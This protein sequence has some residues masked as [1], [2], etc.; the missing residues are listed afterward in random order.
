MSDETTAPNEL[1]AW[2]RIGIALIQS[3][4]LCLLFEA[5]MAET[6]PFT[7][8]P[9]S[10]LVPVFLFA[11]VVAV[12][13]LSHLSPR[14]LIGW[15]LTVAVIGG[16][17]GWYSFTRDPSWEYGHSGQFFLCLVAFGLGAFIAHCLVVAGSVDR[18]FVASYST[19]FETSWKYAVQFALAAAFTGALWLLLLLGAGLF[20]LIKIDL[21]KLLS[22]SWFWIPVTT[23]TATCALHVTDARAGIVH[24]LR[25]L[26][27]NLFSWL[28]P[29][30]TAI[31][32]AFL[33]SLAFTGLEPLWNT[34]KASNILLAAAASLILL[35]NAAY[36]DGTRVDQGG[37]RER[38]IALP[39]RLAI[40]VAS[41]CL[42]PLAG[43]AAYGI[44]LRVNQYGWSPDRVIAAACTLI[45][46]SYALGYALAVTRWKAQFR[47]I[48]ATNVTTAL[49]VV[50]VLI[51]LLTPIADPARISVAS[52]IAR[53]KTGRILPEAFDYAFLR[54]GAGRFG[55]EALQK[56]AE[57]DPTSVVATRARNTLTANSRIEVRDEPREQQT[58][59]S[60]PAPITATDRKE[61]IKV[62]Y[63]SGASL[64]QT[65]LDEDW[66]EYNRSVA[67]SMP[68]CLLS[69][70]SRCEAVIVD[71]NNDAVPEIMLLWPHTSNW[72]VFGEIGGRWVYQGDFKAYSR[73]P[74]TG[75]F[76]VVAPGAREALVTGRFEAV[77]PGAREAL[78]TGRFEV[79]APIY[80]D[81]KIGDQRL[82]LQPNEV[83]SMR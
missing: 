61:Q 83:C 42:V 54:F 69:R 21:F 50:V 17:L 14:R 43:L 79:V 20:H 77:A 53:L 63:P 27:C 33:L 44:S 51:G 78:V 39:L 71:L 47:P 49:V 22:M 46:A 30:M 28:L 80:G 38:A 56:L 32:V 41:V 12:L 65:F 11:P 62:M 13:G 70:A 64:P 59:A 5:G 60:T 36:Q 76:E 25:A 34:R 55:K 35:I 16:A 45:A 26:I 1:A 68:N 6:R 24:V 40:L 9:F 18:R 75:R 10:T 66:S 72:A 81:I 23:L 48:E 7:S 4:T 15:T 29:L 37:G 8:G 31:C 82:H 57:E 3:A 52:Q 2:I 73:C 19:Y 67:Y 58:V 74:V